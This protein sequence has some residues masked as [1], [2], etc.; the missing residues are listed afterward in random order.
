MFGGS[1]FTHRRAP[2]VTDATAAEVNRDGGRNS[3]QT[4]LARLIQLRRCRAQARSDLPPKPTGKLTSQSERRSN[5]LVLDD[6]VLETR[7]ISAHPPFGKAVAAK[8][9]EG[10]AR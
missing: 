4:E 10:P 5:W 2:K 3:R 6:K 1:A 7:A 8:G 9:R